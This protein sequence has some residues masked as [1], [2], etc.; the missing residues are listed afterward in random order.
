MTL[1]AQKARLSDPRVL[2]LPFSA[3]HQPPFDGAFSAENLT[4]CRSA[5]GAVSGLHKNIR[6]V[7]GFGRLAPGGT[8][9]ASSPHN[10][11]LSSITR[12]VL[13]LLS[14]PRQSAL[15]FPAPV[16]FLPPDCAKFPSPGPRHTN[17]S[18]RSP[19]PCCSTPDFTSTSARQVL[20]AAYPDHISPSSSM[21]TTTTTG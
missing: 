18:S 3:G 16:R 4:A 2:Y 5:V 20:S 21:T 17:S 11:Q 1:A 19:P 15:C 13:S 8:T 10:P 6:L 12:L 7:A 9:P 14:F